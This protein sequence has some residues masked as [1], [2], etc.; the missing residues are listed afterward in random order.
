MA[1]DVVPEWPLKDVSELRSCKRAT[2]LTMTSDHL[3][4]HCGLRDARSAARMVPLARGLHLLPGESFPQSRALEFQSPGC[5]SWLPLRG[6][7]VISSFRNLDAMLYGALGITATHV[8]PIGEA[9]GLR[10]H[11]LS[12]ADTDFETECYSSQS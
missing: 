10:D 11:T 9:E 1:S 3:H 7:K 6:T 4:R 2:T 5:G 8:L 12:T